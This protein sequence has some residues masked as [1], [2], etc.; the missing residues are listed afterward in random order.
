[1]QLCHKM[2]FQ[3]RS[4]TAGSLNQFVRVIFTYILDWP[5]ASDLQIELRLK[6]SLPCLYFL[7][8][9]SNTQGINI[10]ILGG[11]TILMIAN[12][13]EEDYGNYT[14]VASNRLG[15]QSASVF[16]YSESCPVFSST[17]QVF[18]QMHRFSRRFRETKSQTLK[19]VKLIDF[20]IFIPLT[21][22][23][24]ESLSISREFPHCGFFGFTL[25]FTVGHL[26]ARQR[27]KASRCISFSFSYLATRSLLSLHE[28]QSS[29]KMFTS[30][31]SAKVRSSERL[32][33]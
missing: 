11:N 21:L 3:E 13:T 10:Q 18:I 5:H 8:R 31:T 28:S 4:W 14:C 24:S 15:A 12:V 22:F 32:K 20:E 6:P 26:E 27:G 29:V 19:P 33:F 25:S 2:C 16:L 9:L 17:Q 7:S 1:M 30:D 23:P